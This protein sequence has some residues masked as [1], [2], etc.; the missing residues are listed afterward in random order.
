VRS[1]GVGHQDRD[2]DAQCEREV[3]GLR[4][5]VS[6]LKKSIEGQTSEIQQLQQ[7]LDQQPGGAGAANDQSLRRRD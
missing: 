2:L 6:D 5:E 3:Q 4:S 7:T 1:T